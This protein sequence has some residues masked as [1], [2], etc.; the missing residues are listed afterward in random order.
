MESL[1]GMEPFADVIRGVDAVRRFHM[2]V[3]P[4]EEDGLEVPAFT[5]IYRHLPA[6]TGINRHQSASIG[7]YRHLPAYR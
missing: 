7:I 4:N 1:A 6:S 5:G 3:M 2:P